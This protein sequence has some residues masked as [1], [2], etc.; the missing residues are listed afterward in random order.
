MNPEKEGV[1]SPRGKGFLT[2]YKAILV[3]STR[4]ALTAHRKVR[5]LHD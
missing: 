4:L 1:P 5:M 2:F 3:D